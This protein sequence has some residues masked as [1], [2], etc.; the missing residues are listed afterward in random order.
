MMIYNW[1]VGNS[2]PMVEVCE[3]SPEHLVGGSSAR[4][5]HSRL[6]LPSLKARPLSLSGFFTPTVRTPPVRV[7]SQCRAARNG[8]VDSTNPSSDSRLSTWSSHEG[9]RVPLVSALLGAS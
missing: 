9:E 5:S 3:N 7:M 8:R 2:G 1:G 6:S 4:R